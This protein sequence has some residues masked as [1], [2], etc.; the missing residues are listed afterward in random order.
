MLPL[1]FV[2][3]SNGIGQRFYA[4]FARFPHQADA[5]GRSFEAQ[6]AAVFGGVSTDELGALE[7]GDDAAH[8]GRAYLFGVGELT[9]RSGAAE[10]KDGERRKL[11]G[12]DVGFAVADAKAAQQVDCGGVELVGD[13][14]CCLGKR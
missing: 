10:D 5:L 2:K 8:G 11:G 12:A 7:A 4:T 14:G 6:A 13:F 3:A 1:V 9:E